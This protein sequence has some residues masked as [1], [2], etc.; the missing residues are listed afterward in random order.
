MLAKDSHPRAYVFSLYNEK[1]I[2]IIV[3]ITTRIKREKSDEKY[4]F[5]QHNGIKETQK[6]IELG[7]KE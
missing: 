7:I 5:Y 3:C 2:A 6:W 4:N 1:I